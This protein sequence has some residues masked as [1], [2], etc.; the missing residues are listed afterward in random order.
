MIS[1]CDGVSWISRKDGEPY[2]L[3]LKS[4]RPDFLAGKQI[5]L[6]SR[7]QLLEGF[8]WGPRSQPFAKER[9]HGHAYKFSVNQSCDLQVATM[10]YAEGRGYGPHDMNHVLLAGGDRTV[11]AGVLYLFEDGDRKRITVSNESFRFCPPFETLTFARQALR[12]MGWE[13]SEIETAD[14]LPKDCP[15]KK[16]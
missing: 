2:E 12:R 5:S 7:S 4:M 1:A 10:T 8:R 16:N 3:L 14:W 15:K 9:H 13:E 6:K 11:T